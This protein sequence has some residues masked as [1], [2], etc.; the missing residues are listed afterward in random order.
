MNM[1]N[2]DEILNL[3]P[4]ELERPDKPVV[5]YGLGAV[6]KAVFKNYS[7]LGFEILAVCDSNPA[8]LGTD[9]NGYKVQRFIDIL[10]EYQDF[11]VVITV[12]RNYYDEVKN[13]LMQFIDEKRFYNIN[14]YTHSSYIACEKYRELLISNKE[15]Y[16]KIFT[17]LADDFSRKVMIGVLKGNVSF[18]SKYFNEVSTAN[19]YFNELTK[20]DRELCFV[21]AGAF[22]GDTLIEFAK[23]TNGNFDRVISL[24]PFQDCFSILEETK[25][26]Y[27]GDDE[28][29]VLLNKGLYNH[30]GKVGFNTTTGTAS[31]K[32]ESSSEA[33]STIETITLDSMEANDISFIKMDIE[34]SELEALMGAQ[35]T[36]MAYKPKLAISVY[37]KPEDLLVIT[38]FIMSLG[39]PYKLYL[40]HH[41]D[42]YNFQN[43]ET[44]IYAI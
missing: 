29:I 44:V 2:F 32:I 23:F 24:E 3:K 17:S 31:T 13:Y 1:I 42:R 8:L 16:S 40:R 25:K 21:D 27:F 18:D 41:G 22:T 19:Q 30:C 9:F 7:D 43:C 36:I 15:R 34:G 37:H 26:N 20:V 6:G 33:S 10:E 11:L 28:R 35:K 39:L 12:G 38:E 14:V 5:L 4:V